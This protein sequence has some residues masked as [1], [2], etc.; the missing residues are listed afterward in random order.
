MILAYSFR[1]GMRG[2]QKLALL[3]Q[4]KGEVTQGFGGRRP[5]LPREGW[6]GLLGRKQRL[7]HLG[8]FCLDCLC[9]GRNCRGGGGIG[10]GKKSLRGIKIF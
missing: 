7:G 9:G 5:P 3:A 8:R 4:D 10:V 1:W 6:A 2:H